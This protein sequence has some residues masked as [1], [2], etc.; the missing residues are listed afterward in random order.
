MSLRWLRGSIWPLFLIATGK[1]SAADAPLWVRLETPVSSRHSAPHSPVEAVVVQPYSSP[2]GLF[3][4]PGSRLTG[5]VLSTSSKRPPSIRI[6]FTSIRVLGREFPFKSRV[7]EV[8]NA[9]ESVTSDGTI[10]GLDSLRKRPGKVELLLMAA[11][12]GHPVAWASIETAKLA[13]REFEHPEVDFPAGTDIAL[14]IEEYPKLNPSVSSKPEEAIASDRLASLLLS[15]PDR[16]Q[17]KHPP[18]P[19]DWINLAFTGSREN[20]DSAFRT[21]GWQTADQLSLRTEVRTFFAV[22]EHHAYH[23]APV[24]TL[25]VAGREPDLVYQKQTN[26]FAKR[27][28]VRI[29]STDKVWDGQAV[30]IAA[31]THDVGIEFSRQ[32]K[33]FTHRVD[34]DVDLERAKVVSD[35]RFAGRVVSVSFVTRPSVPARSQNATGDQIRTD[36]RLAVLELLH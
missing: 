17:A 23:A 35:L 21:A 19:S 27:H 30:W 36:G 31:A 2:A 10:V 16:T 4:P 8:D 15:L 22:A 18:M 32:A 5:T 7:L 26:T 20:L 29:W 25:L 28:H 3:V 12:Y 34:S 24:S 13:I 9:R 14:A 1:V 6:T 33:T 11:V